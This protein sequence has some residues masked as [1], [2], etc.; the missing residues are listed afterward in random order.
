MRALAVCALTAAIL[1]ALPAYDSE[2]GIVSGVSLEKGG[3]CDVR[4]SNI[5]WAYW[6]SVNPDVIG[7]IE[8]PGTSIDGPIAQAPIEPRILPE[9]RR[10]PEAFGKRLFLPRRFLPEGLNSPHRII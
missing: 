7:W 5:D 8:V 4:A 9:T 10:L 6:T 1:A 3:V 2:N